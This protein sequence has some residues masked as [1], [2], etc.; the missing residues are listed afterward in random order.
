M[1][2]FVFVEVVSSMTSSISCDY[3]SNYNYAVCG[4]DFVLFLVALLIP[5]IFSFSLIVRRLHDLGWSA[6]SFLL[7]LV[8]FV[9]IY[10]YFCLYFKQGQQSDNKYGS[11][12]NQKIRFPADILNL[13]NSTNKEIIQGNPV[14]EDQKIEKQRIIKPKYLFIFMLAIVLVIAS[15]ILLNNLVKTSLQRPTK[16][17]DYFA[18][19]V[20]CSTSNNK[21]REKLTREEIDNSKPGVI[22]PMIHDIFLF[23]FYSP[24]LNTCLYVVRRVNNWNYDRK[25]VIQD[26]L[27]DQ[28]INTFT[29]K[30]ENDYAKF[31]FDYSGGEVKI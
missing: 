24:K 12:P 28:E 5:I 27:T 8:P 16:Q 15:V 23:G 3:P 31:I 20:E 7:I 9:N 19:K 25:F 2:S 21:I 10:L 17:Q 4:T 29:E 26:T 1:F 18:K 14:R 22:S 11:K 6:W 30:Q 13:P